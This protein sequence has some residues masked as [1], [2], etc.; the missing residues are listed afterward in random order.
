MATLL[1]DAAVDIRKVQDL[2]G[3]RHITTTQIYARV[4]DAT[5][6][7]DYRQAMAQIARHQL[8]L[9]DAPI[10]VVDWPIQP[11]PGSV[12]V[13]APAQVALDNSV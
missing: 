11:D 13:F 9:S 8:P 6:E 12:E 5:V 2:L 1:L 7:A 4:F 10:P 3:H